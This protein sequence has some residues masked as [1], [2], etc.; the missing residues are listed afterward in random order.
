MGVTIPIEQRIKKYSML[1]PE[2]GCIIWTGY[3]SKNGYAKIDIGNKNLY[4]HRLVF[5]M[6]YGPLGKLTIDHLCRV[7]CCLNVNHLEA[8][9]LR[10][11]IRRGNSNSVR[12]S[13]KTHCPKGHPYNGIL[14]LKD[15][16]QHRFCRQCKRAFNKAKIKKS[17]IS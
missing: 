9:T 11:N 6:K 7:R 8:V 5:E 3:I 4:V 15:G 12:N 17:A 16:R 13:K 2:S 14:Y 10:E 1:I